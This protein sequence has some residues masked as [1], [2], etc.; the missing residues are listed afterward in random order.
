MT[1]SNAVHKCKFC[2]SDATVENRLFVG[3]NPAE[4]EGVVIWDYFG[5]PI[6]TCDKHFIDHRKWD[7]NG[8]SLPITP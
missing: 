7:M 1:E 4:P 2:D 8:K 6:Y 5:E 3:T